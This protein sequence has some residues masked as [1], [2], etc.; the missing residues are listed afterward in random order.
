MIRIAGAQ[1]PTSAVAELV[2][3]MRGRNKSHLA[4]RIENAI[5]AGTYE[6]PLRKHEA[7]ELLWAIERHAV[8]G[9]EPLVAA[10]SGAQEE[11]WGVPLEQR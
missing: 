4:R 8:S 3:H 6:F 1:V 9:L 11:R 2:Q 10:L 7:Q 5:D